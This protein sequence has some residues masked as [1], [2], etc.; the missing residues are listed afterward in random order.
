M[1]TTDTETEQASPFGRSERARAAGAAIAAFTAE[2]GYAPLAAD[3][4]AA[5][6]VRELPRRPANEAPA[7]PT[8]VAAPTAG[9]NT[10]QVQMVGIAALIAVIATIAVMAAV[11][12]SGGGTTSPPASPAGGSTDGAVEFTI[13]TPSN[14]NLPSLL[15]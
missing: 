6:A 4:N 7:R 9:P 14:N 8:V 11:T 10:A 5:A 1:I 15:P 3:V 12:M 13:P 2:T